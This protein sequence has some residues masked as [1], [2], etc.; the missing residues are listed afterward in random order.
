MDIGTRIARA[1]LDISQFTPLRGRGGYS[2]LSSTQ[3]QSVTPFPQAHAESERASEFFG[4]FG[5]A[6]VK[7]RLSA[8]DVLDFGSGYGG[9][10]VE[11]ARMCHARFVWGVEPFAEVVASSNAYASSEGV[12]NV[13][14]MQCGHT[15]IP[16]GDA[17]VDIVISYDVLE[18]VVNPQLSVRELHRVLRPGGFAFL[19]FPVYFGAFSHHLD[20]ISLVPG[21][22]WM[23]SPETLVEAVN[24]VLEGDHGQRFGTGRQPQPSRS[25]DGARAV[26]PSLN[27]LGGEHLDSLFDG[28][29]VESIHRHGWIRRR[30]PQS[31]AM[32]MLS[33][34]AAP[35]RIKDALTSSMSCVL[36]KNSQ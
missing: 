30:Q 29:S 26:L 8:K 23:F 4:F 32:R 24:S 25:F 1:I 15:E 35:T 5:D 27:G 13:T 17:S 22:H 33:E 20:Y 34:S 16:L 36:K 12:S 2:T 18:H 10:T 6:A 7:D 11:Y 14:F 3:R 21:L 31:A 28:F 9:R 19:V